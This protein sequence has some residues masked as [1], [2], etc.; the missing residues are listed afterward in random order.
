M[1]EYISRHSICC[2]WI[3]DWV[4]QLFMFNHMIDY[5]TTKL[6]SFLD[7]NE[8]VPFLLI[9]LISFSMTS[10]IN[11]VQ[12]LILYSFKLFW[13]Q[14]YSLQLLSGIFRKTLPTSFRRIWLVRP[15]PHAKYMRTL[16]PY[17][18]GGFNYSDLYGMHRS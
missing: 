7:L 17:I 11:W 2:Y 15:I 18:T 3:C 16:Y 12:F 5:V 13:L 14:F 6:V 1:I 10:W 8:L 9:N 4:S